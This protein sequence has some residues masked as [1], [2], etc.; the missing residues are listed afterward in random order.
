MIVRSG[1]LGNTGVELLSWG[2][3]LR[4][5]SRSELRSHAGLAPPPR[6]AREKLG[7]VKLMHREWQDRSLQLR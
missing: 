4:Y 3:E 5:C 1:A 7:A 6:V 2:R